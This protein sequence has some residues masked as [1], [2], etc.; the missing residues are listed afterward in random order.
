M[1]DQDDAVAEEW[2]A[3]AA[4]HEAFLQ[5]DIGNTAFVDSGIVWGG[6]SLGDGLLVFAQGSSEAG[7]RGQSAGCEGV[8]P[9]RKGCGV[10]VVEHAG[11]LTDQVV[12]VPELR[13]VIEEPG[14]A[15]VD[16]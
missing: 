16:V 15:V 13:A 7:E 4:S 2:D 8:E 12:G 14:Q 10:A 3:G 6:D 9:A 1:G 11:E 5:L